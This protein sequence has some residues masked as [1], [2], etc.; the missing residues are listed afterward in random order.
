MG[1]V[2]QIKKSIWTDVERFLNVTRTFTPAWL[3][4]GDEIVTKNVIHIR[5]VFIRSMVHNLR[6]VITGRV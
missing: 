2:E 4:H 3:L 5:V 1:A 6:R